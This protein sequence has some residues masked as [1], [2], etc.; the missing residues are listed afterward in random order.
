[1]FRQVFAR[2][3]CVETLEDLTI[4]LGL[5]QISLGNLEIQFLRTTQSPTNPT[6]EIHAILMSHMNSEG[7][8]LSIDNTQ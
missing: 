5:D 6:G 8:C 4:I 3:F 1:M 7:C 2:P